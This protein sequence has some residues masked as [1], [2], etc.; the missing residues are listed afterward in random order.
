MKSGEEFSEVLDI[1]K[2][3]GDEIMMAFFGNECKVDLMR[4]L[5]EDFEEGTQEFV[6]AERSLMYYSCYEGGDF[7]PLMF[8]WDNYDRDQVLDTVPQLSKISLKSGYIY[9]CKLETASGIANYN[10]D[11]V[12][13]FTIFRGERTI[14][15]QTYGG[16]KG[17]L[18]KYV[19]NDINEILN[20]IIRGDGEYYRRLFE[21]PDYMS[22]VLHYD[23]ARFY[24]VKQHLVYPTLKS[25]DKL[26]ESK[27]LDFAK[28]K[29]NFYV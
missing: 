4:D 24:C 26:L 14:L 18:V 17:I 11:Q 9:H 12:H 22:H 2:L 21:V 28:L 1:L 3:H 25:F 29:M 23:V 8:G 7:I 5:R 19:H 6:E 16:T 20:Q 27:G 13:Y 15:L 10:T